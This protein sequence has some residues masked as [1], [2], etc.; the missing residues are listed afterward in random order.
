MQLGVLIILSCAFIT[1]NRVLAS[2]VLEDFR[3]HVDK[4]ARVDKN[5]PFCI[6]G[7]TGKISKL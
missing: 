1:L 2:F 4:L 6:Q 5:C 7:V 3:R